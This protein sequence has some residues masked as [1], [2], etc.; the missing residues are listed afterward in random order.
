MEGEKNQLLQTG[1]LNRENPGRRQ[2]AKNNDVPLLK[3]WRM[4]DGKRRK[5]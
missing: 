1:L 4:L 5:W 3:P 2:K